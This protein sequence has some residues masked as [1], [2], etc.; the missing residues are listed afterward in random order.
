MTAVFL[1]LPKMIFVKY[2]VGIKTGSSVHFFVE[3]KKE[4][5]FFGRKVLT[6]QFS[7]NKC[8]IGD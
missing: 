1:E 6:L 8:K 3:D 4:L 2:R 7:I 5:K